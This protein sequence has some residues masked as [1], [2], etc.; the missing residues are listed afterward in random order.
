MIWHI[1]TNSSKFNPFTQ[2]IDCHL[3]KVHLVSGLE[4]PL[5]FLSLHQ[6]HCLSKTKAKTGCHRSEYIKWRGFANTWSCDSI[7]LI[8]QEP[9]IRTAA[10]G[11]DNAKLAILKSMV[12]W[13][14]AL[15][16]YILKRSMISHTRGISLISHSVYIFN[17]I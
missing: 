13:W 11:L 14:V 3:R 6:F 7:F 12:E 8:I 10:L 15:K 4:N 2:L 17:V 9:T 16:P 5:N 1:S